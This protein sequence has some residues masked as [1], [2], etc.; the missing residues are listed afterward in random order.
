MRLFGRHT[1]RTFA[2]GQELKLRVDRVDMEERE[3]L[4]GV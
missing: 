4:F 2:I 1:G 3:I